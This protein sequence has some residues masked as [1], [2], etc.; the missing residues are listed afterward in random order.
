MGKVRLT[1]RMEIFID[2]DSIGEAKSKFQ[3]MDNTELAENSSFV[4][5]VSADME[6]DATDVQIDTLSVDK[7]DKDLLQDICNLEMKLCNGEIAYYKPIHLTKRQVTL[8]NV[9]NKNDV[10]YCDIDNCELDISFTFDEDEYPLNLSDFVSDINTAFEYQSV[11][12]D[13]TFKRCQ[14]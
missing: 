5:H 9:D 13:K 11:I 6:G 7:V 2:A 4:E 8:K 1:Y 10:K 12:N 3:N 14:D